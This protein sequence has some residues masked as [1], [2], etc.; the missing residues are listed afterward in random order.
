MSIIAIAIGA[1]AGAVVAV[2]G[3]LL[4]D[5]NWIV[6]FAIY[7]LV[8]VITYWPMLRNIESFEREPIPSTLEEASLAVTNMLEDDAF[9]AAKTGKQFVAMNHMNLGRWMRNNWGLWSRS[10]VLYNN[11]HAR[12]GLTHADDMSG[13]ILLLAWHL[14]HGTTMLGYKELKDQ[15]KMYL[16]HWENVEAG[17]P[18]VIRIPKEEIDGFRSRGR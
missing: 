7:G 8:F 14:F 4:L 10:S 9:S 18:V 12:Y 2:G 13:L 15:A 3:A 6:A 11:I 17:N 1:F 5:L 16:E